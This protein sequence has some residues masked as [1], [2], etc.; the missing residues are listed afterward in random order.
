MSATDQAAPASVRSGWKRRASS[1]AFLAIIAVAM[2]GW[3]LG[4]AWVVILAAEWLLA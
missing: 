1:S 2:F 3:L 4:L